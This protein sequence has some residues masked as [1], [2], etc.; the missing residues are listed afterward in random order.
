MGSLLWNHRLPYKLACLCTKSVCVVSVRI[1]AQQNDRPPVPRFLPPDHVRSAAAATWSS[2]AGGPAAASRPR[3]GLQGCTAAFWFKRIVFK[4]DQLRD[5]VY[6]G[7]P[8]PTL[9]A[10]EGFGTAKMW[11]PGRAGF[12]R[13][14]RAMK[15]GAPECGNFD[16]DVF[17]PWKFLPQNWIRIRWNLP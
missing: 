6:S 7:S 2:A 8:K 12:T 4:L 13:S 10:G 3:G 5:P 1:K 16:V 14:H 17:F 9:S 15:H 11:L